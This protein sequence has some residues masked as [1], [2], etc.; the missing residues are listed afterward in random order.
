MNLF[1]ISEIGMRKMSKESNTNYEQ[2]R[3]IVES[4]II[5]NYNTLKQWAVF[6]KTYHLS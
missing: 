1:G 2:H 3:K 6:F 5:S 4:N